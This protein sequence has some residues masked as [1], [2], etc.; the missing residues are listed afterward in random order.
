MKLRL[1]GSP[2]SMRKSRGKALRVLEAAAGPRCSVQLVSSTLD[3]ATT[4]PTIVHRHASVQVLH[5]VSNGGD[6]YYTAVLSE[7]VKFWGPVVRHVLLDGA[8]GALGSAGLIIVHG[9]SEAISSGAALVGWCHDKKS[10]NLPGNL[11]GMRCDAS[12]VD[13]GVGTLFYYVIGTG[14]TNV[15]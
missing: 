3:T 13:D 8:G 10:N 2:A 5:I 14:E 9:E 7:I 15:C 1:K 12:S 6:G 11:V 4:E